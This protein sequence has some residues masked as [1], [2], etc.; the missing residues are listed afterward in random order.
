MLQRKP[1]PAPAR[2]T[3]PDIDAESLERALGLALVVPW[4]QPQVRF[5]DGAL[6]GIE[7]LARWT[8]DES[9][10][11]LPPA[12][13]VQLAE[14]CGLISRLTDTMLSLALH[15]MEALEHTPVLGSTDRKMFGS[16]RSSI[17]PMAFTTPP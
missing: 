14:R 3:V 2:E 1:A 12:L 13:F 15:D 6:A 17:S 10:R 4:Y 16:A 7:V 9:G 8:G 5:S 11:R